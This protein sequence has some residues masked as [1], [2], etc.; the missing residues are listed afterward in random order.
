MVGSRRLGR[1]VLYELVVMLTS[2][3]PGALGL[4][5]VQGA[6]LGARLVAVE[7][8]IG[9]AE[10]R[11]RGSARPARPAQGD[12]RGG[13]RQHGDGVIADQPADVWCQPLRI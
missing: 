1:L 6:E 9:N 12:E 2:W 8:W 11:L 13:R 7:Q 5:P 3:V 4:L 10:H